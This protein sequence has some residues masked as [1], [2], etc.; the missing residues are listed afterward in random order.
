MIQVHQVI[1]CVPA[2]AYDVHDVS[3][4]SRAVSACAHRYHERR[5]RGYVQLIVCRGHRVYPELVACHICG[6]SFMESFFIQVKKNRLT[7]RYYSSLRSCC[8]FVL[9]QHVS[10]TVCGDRVRVGPRSGQVC[11]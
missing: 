2:S 4:K 6:S 10:K 1:C 7:E 8:M 3:D 5:V 11:S 9:A